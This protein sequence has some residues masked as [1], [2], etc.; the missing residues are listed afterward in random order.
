MI[1][2]SLNLGCFDAAVSAGA[3]R[4]TAA[5]ELKIPLHSLR[6]W[7]DEQCV[8]LEKKRPAVIRPE[9]KNMLSE[10]EREQIVATCN[11]EK[12][13][14]LPPSPVVPRL[15]DE[16]IFLASESTMYW[17]LKAASQQHQRGKGKVP[18]SRAKPNSYSASAPNKVWCWDISYLP[19]GIRGRY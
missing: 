3:G 14:S 10:A 9:Q 18:V 1:E 17:V 8:V 12:Y 4:D 13:T 16:N 5:Q 15:A 7:R 19:S 6:R 11:D 2:R